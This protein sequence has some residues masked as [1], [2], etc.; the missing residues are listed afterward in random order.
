M[1]R[2][3]NNIFWIV[4][5]LSALFSLVACQSGEEPQASQVPTTVVAVVEE[6][7][8]TLAPVPTLTANE[9]YC[10]SGNM[11]VDWCVCAEIGAELDKNGKADVGPIDALRRVSGE[12]PRERFSISFVQKFQ[13]RAE[14]VDGILKIWIYTWSSLLDPTVPKPTT[15]NGD[16]VCD[17][18]MSVMENTF[19]G[20]EVV[21]YFTDYIVP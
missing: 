18:Y 5:V 2:Y 3:H 15:F 10:P 8:S 17:S 21:D 13:I 7:A 20:L 12:E 6:P 4:F 1:K 9:I 11:T 14:D 19:P 16:L